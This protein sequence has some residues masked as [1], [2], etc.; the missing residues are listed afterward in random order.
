MD[1]GEE[2][3]RGFVVAG[4]DSAELLE[5]AVEVFDEMACF[6]HFA[7]EITR[8]LAVALWRNDERLA[9]REQRL[10]DARV[11]IKSFVCQQC[12]GLHLRQQRV[13]ALQIMG[14][15]WGKEKAERIAERIDQGVDFGA[16]SA[17]AAPDRLVFA[18]F[19]WAPALCW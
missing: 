14:L 13:R 9:G 15:A 10:D 12:V 17:L 11:G 7:I 18:V 3:S 6:V 19:F 16:Q 5:L 8:S 1:G 2:I 4:G